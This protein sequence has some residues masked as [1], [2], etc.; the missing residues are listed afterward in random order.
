MFDDLIAYLTS[1]F[2][3]R[4]VSGGRGAPEQP[5]ASSIP[6]RPVEGGVVQPR[7]GGQN[8]REQQR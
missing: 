7:S 4:A 8:R 2:G 1:L 6:T 5:A 3:S